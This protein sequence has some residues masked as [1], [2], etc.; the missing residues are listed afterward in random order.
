MPLLPAGRLPCSVAD[1]VVKQIVGFGGK[2]VAMKVANA[3][4][5]QDNTLLS[6]IRDCEQSSGVWKL[7]QTAT[8][9]SVSRSEEIWRDR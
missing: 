9:R 1:D 6:N 3:L 7:V 2:T 5:R 8:D 4:L